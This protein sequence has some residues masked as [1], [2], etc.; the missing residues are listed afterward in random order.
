M[1]VERLPDNKAEILI[2][3]IGESVE[4]LMQQLNNPAAYIRELS[5]LKNPKR[6]KEFLTIRLMLQNHFGNTQQVIYDSSGKPS[7]QNSNLQLSITHSKKHAAIILAENARVGIDIE[8]PSGRILTISKRFLHPDELAF[9]ANDIRALTIIWSA[10]EVLYKII[11]RDAFDF[12][13]QLKI[14]PF[15]P[16][17]TG[18]LDAIHIPTAE[19]YTLTYHVFPEYILVYGINN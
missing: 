19:K 9:S 2:A 1:V 10:K 3:E 6:Q 14:L 5:L 4:E 7:I 11:G 8:I 18:N 17:N 16:G 13:A 12:G 15:I